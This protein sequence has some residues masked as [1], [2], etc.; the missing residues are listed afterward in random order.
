MDYF[1]YRDDQLHVEGIRVAD[2][3]AKY[4]TP[5][6][7][8]SQ[9]TLERHWYAFDTAFGEHPHLIC[10]AVK[11]NSNLAILK[12]FAR[13]GSGFDVVSQGELER[14]L[15]AGGEPQ[16]IVFSGVGKTAEEMK[17]A[18]EVGIYCFNIESSA[19]LYALSDVAASLS[20]KAPISLRI[21]PNVDAKTHPYIAT[22]LHE[23]K[24]G[25][26]IQEAKQFYKKADQL[27]NIE[28]IG[29]DC[30]IGS[31]LTELAPFLE[32]M[33]HLLELIDDLH[34][35]EI[36]IKHLNLGGGLGV[37]Y[38]VETPPH[39]SVYAKAISEKIK[40]S[41]LKII[42]EPGRAIAANAGILV[43]QVL[44]LKNNGAKHF[45]VVDAG[46]N[47]LLRPALYHAWHTILPVIKISNGKKQ[48]YEIVGPICETSDSFGAGREL[49]LSSGDLLV[50]RS[51]GAYGF[52]MSSQYNARPRIP[53]IMIKDSKIHHIRRRET[54]PELYA[55]ESIPDDL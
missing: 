31:Q 34:E 10:Y 18:L 20:M 17:R 26:P 55:L 3:A 9:T 54:I 4:S 45:A 35:A 15:V 1:E 29:V 11:A 22:G 27:S 19:E 42:L 38:K 16:K 49:C 52:V 12:L 6:Y 53:E 43:T 14:V 44:Y 13:L 37:R 24:F 8:Y 46:M 33:D 41:K 40:G 48:I 30:H 5:C 39:P 51:C 23:N 47:D 25:I 32:A 7:I 28:I 50:I 2:I 36:E 21:N